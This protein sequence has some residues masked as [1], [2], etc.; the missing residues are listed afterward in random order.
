MIPSVRQLCEARAY[1]ATG[2]LAVPGE[3]GAR[4]PT[5]TSMASKALGPAFAAQFALTGGSEIAGPFG[6]AVR[7]H[8]ITA[9]AHFDRDDWHAP[10]LTGCRP[11]TVRVAP[12]WAFSLM[13]NGSV[14]LRV[15][16]GGFK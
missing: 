2:N 7:R 9:T 4:W 14:D 11:T 13:A 16:A 6:L 8:Q 5:G 1:D 15:M 3:D 12:P 10:R